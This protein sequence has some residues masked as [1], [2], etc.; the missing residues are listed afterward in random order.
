MSS[1]LR[2]S[3]IKRKWKFH[4]F[5]KKLLLVLGMVAF[6]VLGYGF[7]LLLPDADI[8][9]NATSIGELSEIDSFERVIDQGSLGESSR[10]I[11]TLT[12]KDND[13]L[14]VRIETLRKKFDLAERIV[15][16][17][18]DDESKNFGQLKQLEARLH[19]ERLF[20]INGQGTRVSRNQLQ[21][22]A[23]SLLENQDPDISQISRLVLI[24]NQ[25][26]EIDF[27]GDEGNQETLQEL[28]NSVRKLS[29]MFPNDADPVLKLVDFVKE[30]QSLGKNR[31]AAALLNSVVTAYGENPTPAIQRM[32]VEFKKL[33][34]RSKYQLPSVMTA[35]IEMQ[36]NVLQM[37]SAKVNNLISFFADDP[38]LAYRHIEL[39]N[40]LMLIMQAGFPEEAGRLAEKSVHLFQTSSV[41]K[42]R[43]KRFEEIR[44]LIGKIGAEFNIP[45]A[46]AKNI[47]SKPT[48]IILASS[49]S[50]QQGIGHMQKIGLLTQLMTADQ[51]IDVFAVYLEDNAVEGAFEEMQQKLASFAGIKVLRLNKEDT[52]RFSAE[53]PITWL[54][55]WVV[56]DQEKNLVQVS[57]P[58]PIL[59]KILIDV[60][61]SNDSL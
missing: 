47:Q 17:S 32:V 1:R 33:E 56:L 3:K 57:P 11:K 14:P 36:N 45:Q 26:V 49:K 18:E 41:S 16:L 39:V 27:D 37:N 58:L 13:P 51:S 52:E 42:G 12:V 55:T 6:G 23:A 38:D 8:E 7:L 59:E 30:M 48:L 61:S 2:W 10:F 24:Y 22:Q 43:K 40:S 25:T 46:V 20:N 9:R 15:S 35:V 44:T 60:I 34:L 21:D 53:Y 28:Q 5:G 4:K 29:Q 31:A 54:P 19:L 50:V